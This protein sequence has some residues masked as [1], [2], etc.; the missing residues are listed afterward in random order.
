MD[1][2]LVFKF[3][4]ETL[5]REKMLKH[6]Y[7]LIHES[8]DVLNFS[9]KKLELGRVDFLLARRKYTQAMLRRAA[10]KEVLSS[11]FKIKV[12]KP[13]DL[14]GLK[15][16]SSSNDPKRIHEDMADIEA[17]IKHNYSTLDVN[18]VREYFKLFDREKD[19]DDIIKGVKDA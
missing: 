10:E 16:Q 13:E 15:V 11:R 14:I 8:D 7:G 3:L 1:F 6:G 5:K 19:L 4:V 9:G 12:L 17:I 2:V 18:L